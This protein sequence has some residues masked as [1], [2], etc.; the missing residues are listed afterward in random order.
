MSEDQEPFFLVNGEECCDEAHALAYLLATGVLFGNERRYLD[1][2]DRTVHGPTTV[3]F[4]RCNDLFAWA[5][6]DAE[7]LPMRDIGTLYRMVRADP[8]WG[9]A[10]WCCL[11]RHEQPQAPVVTQMQHDGCWD[12][13]MAQLPS[14]RSEA[15]RQRTRRTVVEDAREES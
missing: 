5:C 6:A 2:Q 12:A 14:N 9:A 15:R 1:G 7:D 4:V 3:L 8:T 10:K 13:Q 11:R